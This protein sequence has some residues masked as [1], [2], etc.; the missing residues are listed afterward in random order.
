MKKI[1]VKKRLQPDKVS[2][3]CHGGTDCRG[4]DCHGNLSGVVELTTKS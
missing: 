3:Y 1:D 4:V 2:D